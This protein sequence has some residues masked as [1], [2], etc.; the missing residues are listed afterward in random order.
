MTLYQTWPAHCLCYRPQSTE[1][2][3]VGY[4]LRKTSEMVYIYRDVGEK[5]YE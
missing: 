4:K 1:R 2:R 5:N 3:G